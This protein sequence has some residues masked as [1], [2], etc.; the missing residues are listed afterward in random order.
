MSLPRFS[1]S[2]WSVVL[3]AA[4]LA[5]APPAIASAEPDV[6]C[7]DVVTPVSLPGLPH[8]Q[9]YGRYCRTGEPNGNPLQI[10]VHGVT[11][12]HTYWDLPGFDGRYSYSGFMN[13]RGYDTLAID[14]LGAGASTRPTLALGVTAESNANA[15]H[16]VTEAVR[17]HGLEGRSYDRIVYTGHSYGTLTSDLAAATYGGVDGIIGTGWTQ[18]PSALGV[19]GIVS[20]FWPAATDPKFAGT[21]LD[22]T[23][24]TTRPGTRGFFYE[25]ADTDPAV[26]ALDEQT[27]NTASLAEADYLVPAN[28]GLTR[29]IGVPTLRQVGE[30]DRVICNPIPCTQQNQEQALPPLFPSGVDVYVEPGA[31]HDLA[32]ERSNTGGFENALAWLQARFPAG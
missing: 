1:K 4:L 14:R 2:L 27:K 32:L 15:L 12:T 13:A 19:A 23:Y 3:V 29:R 24:V 11:Y 16:Q 6:T 21:I 5:V 8:G 28:L 18:Q 22:P 25:A 26:I 10:L 9:I 17:A 30:K 20:T 7:S 31:G